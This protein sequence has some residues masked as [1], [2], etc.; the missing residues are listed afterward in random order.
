MTAFCRVPFLAE[1]SRPISLLHPELAPIY[2]K[3]VQ[4][5][6]DLGRVCRAI[7]RREYNNLRAVCVDVWRIFANCVKY[8]SHPSTRDGAIVSFISIAMHLREFFNALWLEHMVPSDSCVSSVSS[9][10]SETA[11]DEL[12]TLSLQNGIKKRDV[13]RKE[14]VN[15]LQQTGLS[16]K[17]LQTAV[18]SLDEFIRTKG[19]VDA[20]DTESILSSLSMNDNDDSSVDENDLASADAVFSA[21]SRLSEKIRKLLGAG[22]DNDD[23]E[24]R[25]AAL[26]FTVDSFDNEVRRCYEDETILLPHLIPSP[27]LRN[28][29]RR[30]L[31]RLLGKIFALVLEVNGRGGNQSSIWGCMAAVIW[32]RQSTK[33]PYWPALVL[34]IMAPD[35]QREEWHRVVTHRNEAR[36]PEKLRIELQTGKRKAELAI[37]RQNNGT[38]ERMSFFLVEFLGTHEFIWIR[39][40]DIIE[41]FDPNVDPNSPQGSGNPGN[42]TKK[43]KTNLRGQTAATERMRQKAID[44]GK[45]AMQEF[46]MQ[47]GDPCGDIS[48]EEE[49]EEEENYSFAVLC[50]S[51]D[52]ADQV[53]GG[54]IEDTNFLNN[55]DGSTSETIGN[56][57]SPVTPSS[58]MS[59]DNL[60]EVYELL[61]TD[62]LLDYSMEGRKNAKRRAA[63]LKK[64]QV[65]AK[66]EAVKK[67]KEQKT[68]KAKAAKKAKDEEINRK[69]GQTGKSKKSKEVDKQKR[70]TDLENRREQ[71]ELEK[72]RK[73]RERDRERFL[74]EEERKAK[75]MKSG[76]GIK[77]VVKRGRKL[78]IVDKRGRAATIIRGYLNRVAAKDDLKGLGLSGVWGV[79]SASVEASGLLGMT[80][81]FRA[82]AGEI[83]MPNT[84]DNPSIFKPWE[85]IDTAVPLSST[86]RCENLKKQVKLLEDALAK[87]EKDNLRREEQ[88]KEAVS[89]KEKNDAILVKAEKEARKNDMPK[90]KPCIRKKDNTSKKS[91]ADDQSNEIDKEDTENKVKEEDLPDNDNDTKINEL[92]DAKQIS[93]NQSLG[94]EV[95]CIKEPERLGDETISCQS[96]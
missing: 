56:S 39:E 43:K 47:L 5:P 83:E 41:R 61:A 11:E 14:R 6:I 20:L 29:F 7:R 76:D 16:L 19:R 30:R 50:E 90:R 68:R 26:D 72:R 44:E 37:R 8:H 54:L 84:N 34:G 28:I 69:R 35:D 23:D 24:E 71:K 40:A 45:W 67:E 93:E 64:Q 63:A 33:K 27:P 94:D 4:L 80:L 78:G 38:A 74:K 59:L 95:S 91:N 89:Q 32:A 73:K 82:A 53:E 48:D 31:N 86:E 42:I 57:S 2:S 75:K 25:E 15:A 79:P 49:E 17:C 81:A 92:S 1:F 87:L 62:G 77:S 9:S 58:K 88:V 22:E 60:D 66:R 36:L 46:D 70:L 3:V 55:P 21:L 10:S 18:N 85:K 12:I 96:G 13:I 65:D 51:D 52:E